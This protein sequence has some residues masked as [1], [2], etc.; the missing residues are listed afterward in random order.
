MP[1]VNAETV[2]TDEPAQKSGVTVV[3]DGDCPFCSRYVAML[4]LKK[5]VGQV[6]LFD[7]RIPHSA[8]EDVIRRGFDLDEGMVV[9]IGDAYYAGAESVHVLSLLS[10]RTDNFNR[11]NYW[12]FRSRALSRVVYPVL[13]FGRN[14]TLRMLGRR[15][16]GE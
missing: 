15:K 4:R 7:A 8:V 3:Y 1:K 2:S 11:I 14:L 6:R 5:T 16:I 9:K 12:L 13:R 10:T